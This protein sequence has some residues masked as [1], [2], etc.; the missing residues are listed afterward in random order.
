[1]AISKD[2]SEYIESGKTKFEA[3]DYEGAIDDFT[4]ALDHDPN[5]LD[6][7]W[8]R[9]VAKSRLGSH[10]EANEDFSRVQ[11]QVEYIKRGKLKFKDKDY[12]GAIREFTKA[13]KNNPKHPDTFRNRGMARYHINDF[14]GAIDDYSQ[15]I[16]IDPNNACDYF[17]RGLIKDELEDYKDAIDDYSK[18]IK[19]DPNYACYYYNRG[20]AKYE[21]EDMDGFIADWQYVEELGDE[22]EIE[23]SRRIDTLVK[24][25]NAD[26]GWWFRRLNHGKLST[27][28]VK[29]FNFNELTQQEKKII[30]ERYGFS[31]GKTKSQ[32]DVAYM[33]GINKQQVEQLEV[34]ALRKFKL[35]RF[36]NSIPE[37]KI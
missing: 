25:R 32:Q 30:Y 28:K 8:K 6:I 18:S 13:L 7:L 26:K 20:L 4:K 9:G 1:M 27:S 16:K 19:I 29:E 17:I 35:Q 37:K 36:N 23:E 24:A 22:L 34:D 3:K 33:I 15:A 31:D 10:Q 2:H 11:E 21:L 12:E 14:Q 5:E